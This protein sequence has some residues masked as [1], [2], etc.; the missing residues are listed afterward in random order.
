[1]AQASSSAASGSG[2][3]EC[4]GEK[5]D[6]L[7]RVGLLQLI[8]NVEGLNMQSTPETFQI[9]LPRL[10]AVQDQFQKVIVIATR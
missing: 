1:M 4:K 6:K 8:S 3:P 10:R 2:L 7:T 9:N 5:I